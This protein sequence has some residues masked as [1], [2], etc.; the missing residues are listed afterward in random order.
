MKK[1]QTLLALVIFAAV[2]AFAGGLLTNTNQSAHFLRN[3]ALDATTEID[4][5]YTNPAGL[6]FISDGIHISFSN[7][8]VFQTRTI[9]SNFAPFAYNGGSADKTFLGEAS[10]PIIPSIQFAYKKDKIAFSAGFAITGGGGKAVFN[11][12]LPSFEAPISMLVPSLTAKGINTTAYSVDGFMEGRQYI[13]GVQMNGSYKINYVLSVALGLR[14]NMVSNSYIGHLTN[15]RINPVH[16]TF[17][18]TGA[19]MLANTFFTNA[20]TAATGAAASLNPIITAG[21]GSNTLAQLVASGSLTSA[22]VTQ[23]SSGLGKNVS[24]MTASQVQTLYNNAATTYTANATNTAD[25]NLNS[26]QSGWGLT[27]IISINYHLE[28]LNI[29]AKYEMKSS[30]DVQNETTIDDTGLYPDGVNTPNDI[31]AFLSVGA[32]Y[33][34]TKS[35]KVSGGYHHFFDSDAKMAND[36]QQYIKGG[37]NEYMVG[38]EYKI[39]DM[40]LISAGLQVTRTGV[41]DSYQSDLSYSLNSY[42]VGFGGAVKITPKLRL[43]LAYFFTNYSDW[44][45]NSTN[46]N[47]TTLTGSDVYGRTNK[48]FGIGLDYRFD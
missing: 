37:I 36:K 34:L 29:A 21:A 38:S 9:K 1:K 47:G 31:P 11:H 8:S 20:A 26:K 17:N 39:N 2:S 19:M 42:S 23:L 15:I 30:L 5:V 22:Q 18:P 14:L 24:A 6:M 46:Y 13:F 4:A 44:T 32:E 35:W 16:P 43:N 40:L 10:A 12:G 33:D 7:Q 3:P 28:K 41:T 25:K 45:K 48:V 27:P